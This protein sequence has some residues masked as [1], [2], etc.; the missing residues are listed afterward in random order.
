ME[1]TKIEQFSHDL[2]IQRREI[3]GSLRQLEQETRSLEIESTQDAADQCVTS[4]SKEALFQQSSQRRTILRRIEAAL[5]RIDDGSFGV[6]VNCGNDIPARR[7]QALP[8]TQFCLQCQEE[9]EQQGHGNL[10]QQFPTP[11][12]EV[13]KRAG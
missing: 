5:R 1:K 3:L 12:A 2:E 9:I 7:L 13:W 6:C 11:A 8:W 4:M 10:S